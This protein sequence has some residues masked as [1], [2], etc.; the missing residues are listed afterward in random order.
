[1][2]RPEKVVN[3]F[4]SKWRDQLKKYEWLKVPGLIVSMSVGALATLV[5]PIDRCQDS[6]AC[7]ASRY[8]TRARERCLQFMARIPVAS[9]GDLGVNPTLRKVEWAD[10]RSR[11]EI[12]YYWDGASFSGSTGPEDAVFS[13]HYRHEENRVTGANLSPYSAIRSDTCARSCR[14]R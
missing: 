10:A 8:E 3:E 1:M 5:H 4:I 7:L 2:S 11:D 6:V 14:E 9:I 12:T 13:C